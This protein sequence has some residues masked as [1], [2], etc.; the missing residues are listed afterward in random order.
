MR[1]FTTNIEPV[2]DDI[3]SKYVIDNN[4][5]ICNYLQ[6]DLLLLEP[7]TGAEIGRNVIRISSKE[8]FYISNIKS[9]RQI[10]WDIE[11]FSAAVSTF[12]GELDSW[13]KNEK[14]RVLNAVRDALINEFKER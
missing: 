4:P 14:Q 9:L 1:D 11:D 13:E 7:L 8:D 3:K 12:T 5:D 10:F 2:I 6:A